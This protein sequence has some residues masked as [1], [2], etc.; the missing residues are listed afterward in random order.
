MSQSCD[1]SDVDTIIVGRDE[2][3]D[4]NPEQIL[5]ESA[6]TIMDIRAWLQPTDYLSESGE[7]RKHLASH[8]PGTGLWITVNEKYQEWISGE[9]YGLLW[10]KGIPGSGK[11]V[12]A[13]HLIDQL[14]RSNSGSPILYFFF[15]QIIDANHKPDALLRDWLSQILEYSPPLQKHLKE[16][17]KEHRKIESISPQDLWKDLRLAISGFSNTVFCV[18]DALDE[19]DVG[20]EFFLECL[21]TFSQWKPGKVKVLITS[22]PVPRI[23]DPLRLA[24]VLDIRL[25]DSIV[26]VDIRN[27]VQHILLD[28]SISD[29]DK[30]SIQ[31]A[32][33]GRANGL[34]LYARLAMDAFLEP[35]ATIT[36][37]LRSLPDDLNEMYTNLLREHALR[38][39]V[40]E[41]IQRIILQSVTHATRPLRLLE[42]AE[43]INVTHRT[44]VAG[45]LRDTK[46]LVRAAVGPLLEILPDET[47]C[48]IHHSFTEYLKGSTR[49]ENDH[50][51]PPLQPGETHTSLAR[52]C[53]AYLQSGALDQID[54][55]MESITRDNADGTT[56]DDELVRTQLNHPFLSY[57][58]SN[59]HIHIC[60]SSA[61]EYDQS[62]MNPLV[63]GFLSQQRYLSAWI[64]LAW[65]KIS[66]RNTKLHI[67]AAT[68]LT[69]YAKELLN[70]AKQELDTED[71]M[72]KTAV[73][74]AADSG[75]A[76]ILAILIKSG[77]S[78]NKADSRYGLKPLHRAAS[79]NHFD[80]VR[81]LLSAGVSPLTPKSSENPG[82]YAYGGKR[83]FGSTALM[84]ACHNGHVD[85]I[86]VFLSFIQDKDTL[87][88]MLYWASEQ[89]HSDAVQKI[90]QHSLVDVNA[91]V[92]G[93]TAL[94]KA[95]QSGDRETITHLV[96]AGADPRIT[97]QEAPDEFDSVG[98]FG[99][100]YDSTPRSYTALHKLCKEVRHARGGTVVDS[101]DLRFL[102]SLLVG[103][104]AD[105]HQGDH[106][107][108]KP[109]HSALYNPV[110]LELLLDAG[111]NPNSVSKHGKTPL[112]MTP[113][114]Q[115]RDLLIKYGADINQALP[116]GGG[117]PLLCYLAAYEP[118]TAI[119]FLQYHPHLDCKDEGGNGVLHIAL[120][121]SKGKFEVTKALLAAGA[122]PKVRNKAG[123][124]P[125]QIM[126][127]T[128]ENDYAAMDLLLEA[129]ADINEK[130]PD[131]ASLLFK[132]CSTSPLG[133]LSRDHSSL[134]AF[135]DRGA[136]IT[137]RDSKGRTLLHET[138]KQHRVPYG[139]MN[140]SLWKSSRLSFLL[141]RG[142]NLSVVDNDGNGLFHELAIHHPSD[143]DFWKHLASLGLDIDQP[144]YRGRTPLHVICSR[145][146]HDKSV[147]FIFDHTQ[148]VNI[149]D[150]DGQTP[151]HLA[152][153][154]SESCTKRLLDLG[155]DP[156]A[157]NVDN[158]TPLHLATRSRQPNIVGLLLEALAEKTEE[159]LK[160]RDKAGW[161][162][163]SHACRSGRME[164]FDLLVKAGSS[165]QDETMLLYACLQF[166]DEEILWSAV[167]QKNKTE[168]GEN[169]N[170]GGL[171]WSDRTRP[172][173]D[174]IRSQNLNLSIFE[175]E[176][177][178]LEEILDWLITHGADLSPLKSEH[179]FERQVKSLLNKKQDYTASCLLRN[180]S[181]M[182]EPSVSKG[183]PSAAISEAQPFHR[184]VILEAVNE[185]IESFKD[186]TSGESPVELVCSLLKRRQYLAT[187]RLYNK[188]LNF[189]AGERIIPF[190]ILV[191]HGFASLVESIGTLEAMTRFKQG[192]GHAFGDKASPGLYFA[193]DLESNR[194]S[195]PTNGPF[196]VPL[197][198]QAVKRDVP[199]I[200]VVKIL[201]EKLHVDIDE[202]FYEPKWK[203]GRI[204]GVARSRTATALHHLAQGDR[205]WHTS[206][207]LP[208]LISRG[209]DVN[210]KNDE[211]RTPLLVALSG[212]RRPS[213]YGHNAKSHMWKVAE[214][215]LKAGADVNVMDE[216]GEGCLAYAGADASVVRLLIDHGAKAGNDALLSAIKSGQ[217]QALRACLSEGADPNERRNLP[218]PYSAIK[219]KPKQEL[220]EKEWYPL[221]H[222]ATAYTPSN[223]ELVKSLLEYGADPF[224][225]YKVFSKRV[226]QKKEG[227]RLL[228]N[229]K[230]TENECADE[231]L[232]DVL[233]DRT[234]LHDLLL[235]S[236]IVHPILELEDL[237]VDS[238]DPQGRTLLHAACHSLLGPDSALD[239]AIVV[240]NKTE[241][242]TRPTVLD[243][244]M[245]R[246]ADP[247]AR[248][249]AGRNVLHYMF[250]RFDG[251]KYPQE[252]EWKWEDSYCNLVMKHPSLLNARDNKGRTPFHVAAELLVRE[253]NPG[254]IDGLMAAEADWTL[255]DNEG[256]TV[257]H[258]LAP[259]LNEYT[260]VRSRV[261]EILETGP[262]DINTL[263]NKGETPI[264][265]LYRQPP[266]ATPSYMGC[267]PWQTNND[268]TNEA[269]A[270]SIFIKNGAD[271]R[272][273]NNAEQ[274]LLHIAATGPVLRF[275]MLLDEGLNPMVEDLNRRTAL[276]VAAAC[277]NKA[278]LALFERKE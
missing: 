93:D 94:Y 273:V 227:S 78:P 188:G 74:F 115:A 60:K 13:A 271:L 254:P 263:N 91:K 25:K 101:E 145:F 20:N 155:A 209:A 153:T 80:V 47:L 245:S 221:Q 48:V 236:D 56:G 124:N 240:H 105:I 235:N 215:L 7:Y 267:V 183:L 125:L 21:K 161:T 259:L 84:Y 164:T 36:A 223:V 2:V 131:G 174:D 11:S 118:E 1:S 70:S 189:F 51:Y 257:I 68:G 144:N 187:V 224:L 196:H 233:E 122:D 104:G 57:A 217:T 46:D 35:G 191:S 73:W 54:L 106:D 141:D 186:V 211:G 77:A 173:T 152:A 194:A 26:D 170:A 212:Y 119:S 138:V 90:L 202:I 154:I 34:F 258:I 275:K 72:G 208:Y 265:G 103:A 63:D 30:L 27:Y 266:M 76:D 176:T 6:E 248:D 120:Q 66:T 149:S 181:R 10:L 252:H 24:K 82:V 232:A 121:R 253:R 234:V 206:L 98:C 199:N 61:A 5:P 19:M 193:L 171:T 3:N 249:N 159:A 37:V 18:A 59:W 58:V 123:Q 156:M 140:E 197:I 42:L 29:N 45:V 160:V 100:G 255:A 242:S 256:N 113:P 89:G 151:L 99:S 190:A 218:E 244:L 272:V 128:D 116:G 107:G 220:Q 32:I 64:K 230:P 110:M 226:Y 168:L 201:V 134:R 163:L 83:S 219:W 53:L 9:E 108:F 185:A 276:D 50:G 166:E 246:G 205:W 81:I 132:A 102:F 167:A 117:T 12:L 184:H 79:K 109:V 147:D 38:S 169:G 8:S 52:S 28:S 192:T 262:W 148:G 270:F 95:C 182:I 135:L 203:D 139:G 157:T 268:H 114:A 237:D 67:A 175:I 179:L 251:R 195:D 146:P 261:V 238:R 241:P 39:A 150:R 143:T 87:S 126:K 133:T 222:A 137:T 96:H 130:N 278:V 204:C 49:N 274:G 75:N 127:L 243:F 228:D 213:R 136:D 71:S 88:R 207:A 165:V 200:E 22:R 65:G 85:T 158:M 269:E 178:R 97:C 229:T 43:M 112:H 177:V 260:G 111:A 210:V 41:F 14:S 69:K 264:F 92:R 162:V 180:K 239:Q 17:L 129:G 225:K 216:N 4:Y 23:E 86:G 15:R 250:D 55:E 198:L 33:P 172:V 142:L 231:V 62:T 40:P 214:T 31:E 44:E 16:Y 247:L 277:G